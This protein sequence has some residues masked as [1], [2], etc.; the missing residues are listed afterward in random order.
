MYKSSEVSQNNTDEDVNI[1]NY[2]IICKKVCIYALLYLEM[3]VRL[4]CFS[5]ILKFQEFYNHNQIS[6]TICLNEESLLFG[7]LSSY[8]PSDRFCWELPSN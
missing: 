3:R 1:L 8:F 7:C 2:S 4:I 5:H 6:C